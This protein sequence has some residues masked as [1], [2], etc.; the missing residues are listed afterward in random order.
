MQWLLASSQHTLTAGCVD[1]ASLKRGAGVQGY[2]KYRRIFCD[3][4]GEGSIILVVWVVRLLVLPMV[5][6]VLVVAVNRGHLWVC[7]VCVGCTC[8][9]AP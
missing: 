8:R 4:T 7:C 2:T 5:V 3:N 6:L 1:Y 9:T